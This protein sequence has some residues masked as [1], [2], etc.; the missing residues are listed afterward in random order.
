M[1]DESF[2]SPPSGRPIPIPQQGQQ[3]AN[4]QSQN[5]G[6]IGLIDEL[7]LRIKTIEEKFKEM[8][9]AT[10]RIVQSEV[11]GY[12]TVDRQT[13]LM[14]GLQIGLCVSTI[15]P[16]KQNRVRF[17]HPAFYQPDLSVKQLPFAFAI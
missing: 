5:Q 1:P 9:Y 17:Y 6:L 3:L 14:Q 16:L 11:S 4:L 15:D 10:K 12:Y 8:G 7:Q 2:Q 13:E